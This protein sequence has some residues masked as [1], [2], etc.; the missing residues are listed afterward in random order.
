[1]TNI[2]FIIFIIILANSNAIFGVII[3]PNNS[4][5]PWPHVPDPK[6]PKLPLEF[7]SNVDKTCQGIFYVGTQ[8]WRT[9]PDYLI[10]D[11]K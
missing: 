7:L 8:I 9:V 4:N 10:I 1:M 6:F 3:S 5:K 11:V 2:F